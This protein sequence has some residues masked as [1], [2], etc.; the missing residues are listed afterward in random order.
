MVNMV[1]PLVVD[2]FVLRVETFAIVRV[3]HSLNTT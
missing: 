1:R 3:C 2:V